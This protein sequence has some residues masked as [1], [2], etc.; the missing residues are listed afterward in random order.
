M[1]SIINEIGKEKIRQEVVSD[2]RTSE[3][4]CRQVVQ[5]TRERLGT[6]DPESLG[7]LC[8]AL[9]HFMLTAAVLPSQRKLTV[10]GHEVDILVPSSRILLHDPAKALVIQV[11]KDSSDSLKVANAE[12]LQQIRENIWLVS[13]SKING[14]YRDYNLEDDSY[15]GIVRDIYAFVSSKGISGLK[16]VQGE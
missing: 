7:T 13:S 6:S 14:N 9:L 15:F 8:E 4:H 16:L 12:K 1:Y 11:M 5:G 2:I 3:T 10:N